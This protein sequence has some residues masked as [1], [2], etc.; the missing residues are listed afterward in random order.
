MPRGVPLIR[1][2]AV[3]APR[4]RES[5]ERRGS[6]NGSG[7]LMTLVGKLMPSASVKEQWAL[8]SEV[9]RQFSLPRLPV[10]YIEDSLRDL[11]DHMHPDISTLSGEALTAAT[12]SVRAD[13][14]WRWLRY[15]RLY[16]PRLPRYETNAEFT[17]WL[18]SLEPARLQRWGG[19]YLAAPFGSLTSGEAAIRVA[20]LRPLPL[21]VAWA[22]HEAGRDRALAAYAP[23]SG[24]AALDYL[25]TACLQRMDAYYVRDRLE[26]RRIRGAQLDTE[27][28]SSAREALHGP[29]NG[30]L[31]VSDQVFQRAERASDAA[32]TAAQAAN[33]SVTGSGLSG[34]QPEVGAG[35]RTVGAVPDRCPACRTDRRPLARSPLNMR[36]PPFVVACTCHF[37]FD[38]EGAPLREAGCEAELAAWAARWTRSVPYPFPGR[39]VLFWLAERA[40]GIAIDDPPEGVLRAFYSAS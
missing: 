21:E 30:Q 38:W 24:Q 19:T 11:R 28:K 36:F 2:W 6:D 16:N 35:P 7:S 18:H 25:V 3:M 40:R 27:C 34:Q 37:A 20:R 31:T 39:L 15:E 22:W 33:G 8:F 26:Y 17:A 9:E 4:K 32:A 29:G 1:Q 10:P 14:A 12:V 23:S 5:A 13:M